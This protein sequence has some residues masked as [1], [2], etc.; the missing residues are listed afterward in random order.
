MDFEFEQ[1]EPL[2]VRPEEEI[3]NDL[4]QPRWDCFCCR[5]SGK[6]SPDLVRR[7]IPDYD[8]GRDRLPI[9]QN[10]NRGHDWYHLHT[11]DILDQRISFETCRKLDAI[12]REDWRL[13][14]QALFELLKKRLEEGTASISQKYNL[15]RRN[16]IQEE[17]ILIQRNHG[18]ARGDWE[19][20]PE[21]KVEGELH[22]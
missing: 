4:W 19:E 6:I 20:I 13:T 11:V 2:P 9:C 22:E 14:T 3:E 12:A 15:R 21:E 16:R 1:L 18:K 8:Y 17:F 7:V 5:D 10:C